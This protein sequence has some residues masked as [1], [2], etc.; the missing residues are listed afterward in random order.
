MKFPGARCDSEVFISRVCGENTSLLAPGYF[1]QEL[2]GFYTVEVYLYQPWVKGGGDGVYQ[3]FSGYFRGS[4][5]EGLGL[6]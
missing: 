4:K 5:S 3:S 2:R 1:Q 6:S